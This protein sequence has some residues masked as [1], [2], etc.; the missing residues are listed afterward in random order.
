MIQVTET[1]AIDDDE[2]EES[3]IR[4]SGPGGQNVN[5]VAT[6]VELRFDVDASPG[7]SAGVRVRLKR[8]AGNRMTNNGVLVIK[9][10]RFRSQERNRE[11]A[12]ERLIALIRQAAVEPRPRIRTRP[13]RA[14]K[15]RRLRN[16]KERSE[17]K[18]RR[19][20]KPPLD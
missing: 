19:R 8:L 15:E 12:R 6:A 11:D 18:Q 2:L 16:K 5:R 4:A 14:A 17:T 1:I 20:Q 13:S 10:E 9:A 3:F 7:L